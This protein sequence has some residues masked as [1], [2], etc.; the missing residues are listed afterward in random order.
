MSVEREIDDANLEGESAGT[1]SFGQH[2]P[3][4]QKST[5]NPFGPRAEGS[6]HRGPEL[7]ADPGIDSRGSDFG[8]SDT[9]T[10]KR[11][12]GRPKGSTNAKSGGGIAKLTGDKLAAA[13]R[14][15]TE[16][17]AGVVGFTVSYYGVTRAN[18]YKRISPSLAQEVYNGYQITKE[19]AESVG[20]PLADT[21]I[22]WFPQYVETTTKAI[23]PG[24]AIARL[25]TIF[26]QGNENEKRAAQRFQQAYQA[27]NK[28]PEKPNNGQHPEPET[29][30]IE[31]TVN[32]WQQNQPQPED[33]YQTIPR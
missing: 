20:E 33:V 5:A 32:E 23:D 9:E 22:T 26:Q 15:L 27:S 29:D 30:N 2:S 24:L 31:E 1:V 13:R 28:G 8:G 3:F 25:F 6:G 21:Y 17:L 11:K 10:P 14:K 4:G 19:A 18:K 7:F 16:S 12:R